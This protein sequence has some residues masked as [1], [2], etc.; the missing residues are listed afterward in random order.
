MRDGQRMGVSEVMETIAV[1]C[2]RYSV[3]SS[4]QVLTTLAGN[5]GKCEAFAKGPKTE[6]DIWKG[7][8]D[9]QESKVSQKENI[10]EVDKKVQRLTPETL[11]IPEQG[12]G[13]Q[14]SPMVIWC[15]V[16]SSFCLRYI[17]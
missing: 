9:I 7:I 14:Y 2:H 10:G 16:S 11:G 8:S 1:L 3:Q 5:K 12:V 6:E 17:S 15:L 4:F 13:H